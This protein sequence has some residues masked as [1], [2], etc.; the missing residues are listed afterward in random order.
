[1]IEVSDT[2]E[3]ILDRFFMYFIQPAHTAKIL[4]FIQFLRSARESG[5]NRVWFDLAK[6]ALHVAVVP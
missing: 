2:G 5:Y 4:N 3:A 6:D 1:M